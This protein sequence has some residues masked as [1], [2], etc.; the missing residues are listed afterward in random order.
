MQTRILVLATILTFAAIGAAPNATACHE[1]MCL[2]M[3]EAV[4]ECHKAGDMKTVV[5]C[6]LENVIQHTHLPS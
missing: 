2:D 1:T 3:V 5:S 4:V 6:D